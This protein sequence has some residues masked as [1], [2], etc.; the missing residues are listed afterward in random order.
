MWVAANVR[1]VGV[2]AVVVDQLEP[3]Q[4]I[5]DIP[6]GACWKVSIHKPIDKISHNFV[7]T[8]ISG[9]PGHLCRLRHTGHF[10]H[11]KSI[12]DGNRAKTPRRKTDVLLGSW[13]GYTL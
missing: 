5:Q 2:T 3:F 12:H 8:Y 4:A 10:I 11:R 1:S 7:S 6:T 9:L 13:I